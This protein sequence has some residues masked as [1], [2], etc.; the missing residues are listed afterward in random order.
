M[1]NRKTS[2]D[3]AFMQRADILRRVAMAQ[4]A[5]QMPMI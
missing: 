3:R 2:I 5:R 1:K 4:L